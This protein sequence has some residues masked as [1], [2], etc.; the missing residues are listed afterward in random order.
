MGPLENVLFVMHQQD[1]LLSCQ[2]RPTFPLG[3]KEMELYGSKRIS[4]SK[5]SE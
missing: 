5:R 2:L 3:W 4:F 1:C